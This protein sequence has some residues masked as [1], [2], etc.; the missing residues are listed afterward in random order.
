MGLHPKDDN[1]LQ[2]IAEKEAVGTIIVP[3]SGTVEIQV[4][5]HDICMKEDE[6]WRLMELFSE[7]S[8]RLMEI[9]QKNSGDKTTNV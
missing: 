7:A 9:H 8:I 5:E 1:Q 4:F 3:R 6:Y 2:I